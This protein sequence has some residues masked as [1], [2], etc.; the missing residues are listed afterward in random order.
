MAATFAGDILKCIFMDEK[1]CVSIPI[2]WKFVPKGPIDNEATLVQIMAWA[3]Y[4][5]QAIT[6]T[7]ADPVHWHIYTSLGEDELE[8]WRI[9]VNN[10]WQ[11][12][13][14]G[15]YINIIIFLSSKLL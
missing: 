5:R 13:S 6:L 3:P 4:R 11:G 9:T 12:I 2:P 1:F 15:K 10:H 7:N 8:L 14:N